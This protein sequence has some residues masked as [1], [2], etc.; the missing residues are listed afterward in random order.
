MAIAKSN[1]VVLS[2]ATVI[3]GP[4]FGSLKSVSPPLHDLAIIIA[5]PGAPEHVHV[6]HAVFFVVA[7]LAQH[8]PFSSPEGQSESSKGIPI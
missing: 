3:G 1:V 4:P 7:I 5:V 2:I 6:G 8:L